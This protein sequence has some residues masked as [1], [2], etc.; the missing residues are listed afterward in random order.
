MRRSFRRSLP[1]VFALLIV[2][3]DPSAVGAASPG[4]TEVSWDLHGD[5][6]AADSTDLTAEHSDASIG[7]P[8]A[9]AGTVVPGEA[10]TYDY[11]SDFARPPP[12]GSA[13]YVYDDPANST[14]PAGS[15][16]RVRRVLSGLVVQ[17]SA[18][19]MADDFVD[20]SSSA[21]RTHI[22]HGD[23]TGGGHLWPGAAGKTPFP[24]S[25][26]G[27]RIMHEISDIATDPIAWRGAIPQGS[28]TVLTGTRGR[29][30]IRVIVD[31][32][33]GEIKLRPRGWC[34]GGS[35]RG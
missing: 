27:D 29:V 1:L 9:P 16:G 19:R 4:G 26:S 6:A 2:G 23:A 22:L 33:T 30:D 12:P 21:R 5:F 8:L 35:P 25:W 15:L 20:L 17:R 11:R 31:S 3:V 7:G 28:R 32:R 34:T 10:R 18:P 13:T 24:R 14:D